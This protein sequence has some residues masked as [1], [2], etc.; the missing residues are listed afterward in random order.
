ML[1]NL[2][3]NGF[4]NQ[5]VPDRAHVVVPR[6][7]RVMTRPELAF[8]GVVGIDR[9]EIVSPSVLEQTPWIGTARQIGPHLPARWYEDDEWPKLV[10]RASSP[11]VTSSRSRPC[12]FGS[13]RG[14]M[15]PASVI[16]RSFLALATRDRHFSPTRP[17]RCS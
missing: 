4:S 14:L 15:T 1:P 7:V 6:Q 3:G 5:S 8:K 16:V 17:S 13:S 10:S 11:K 9:Y 12:H 2:L